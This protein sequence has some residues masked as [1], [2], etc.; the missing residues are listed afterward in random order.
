MRTF[1]AIDIP[2]NDEIREL[3]S[4]LRAN[5]KGIDIKYTELNNSHL[6]LA[7]LGE[8]TNSEVSSLC[9]EL[10][11]INL[12]FNKIQLGLKG[13]GL[14]KN[15]RTPSVIWVGIEPNP[16]LQ[17]IWVKIN[18]AVS[19]IGISID[20]KEFQPHLTLGRI[21]RA[22]VS[23]NLDSFKTKYQNVSFG[24]ISITGFVFYQSILTPNGPI[25]KPIRK[26]KFS[27]TK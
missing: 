22:N 18:E 11:S 17:E 13:L 10:E 2:A 12:E 8:T 24:D 15:G 5:L 26:F 1:I 9:K 27:N 25:Y 20:Q 23:H 21:K 14:F 3:L 19:S 4:D 7:F 16:Q 6:T